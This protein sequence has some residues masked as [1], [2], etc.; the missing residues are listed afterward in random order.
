[1][2]DFA[3]CQKVQKKYRIYNKKNGE[4]LLD[5]CFIT[6]LNAKM[7]YLQPTIFFVNPSFQL[8]EEFSLKF[9]SKGKEGNNNYY[10]YV[11]DTEKSDN[12]QKAFDLIKHFLQEKQK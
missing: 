11:L 12:W 1:M 3:Q 5:I 8:V 10:R 4:V 7:F 9:F 2:G 6:G